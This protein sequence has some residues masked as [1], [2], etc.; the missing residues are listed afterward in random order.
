VLTGGLVAAVIAWAD[1]KNEKLSAVLT[2]L[3]YTAILIYGFFFKPQEELRKRRLEYAG[4]AVVLV[5]WLFL[6]YT[7]FVK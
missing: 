3:G 5:F 4:F 7:M 6:T 1:R 2:A